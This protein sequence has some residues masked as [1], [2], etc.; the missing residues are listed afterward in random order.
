MLLCCKNTLQLLTSNTLQMTEKELHPQVVITGADIKKIDA[1]I[2]RM[3]W[4]NFRDLINNII[5]QGA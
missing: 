1:S 4:I 3:Q 2:K 5:M